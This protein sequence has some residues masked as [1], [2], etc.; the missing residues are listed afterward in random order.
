MDKA[1][2]T[3]MLIFG[4]VVVAV[5]A[6]V[7]LWAH[8]GYRQR[9]AEAGSAWTAIAGRA[10]PAADAFSPDMI[11]G[12]PEVARRYFTHAIA[13]GTPLSTTVELEMEGLFRLGEKDAPREFAMHARQ[14]LAPPSEFVW[15]P[16]LRSGLLRVTGSD[17]LLDG[18]AWTRFWLLGIV[19]L[20]QA[21]ATDALYRSAL[22]RPALEAIWAPASLLP[23]SGA[24]WRQTG[25]DSARIALG[26]GRARVEIDMTVDADGRVLAVSTVRWSDANRERT[27]RLQPFGGTMKVEATF[28][29]FTIPVA[30][31]VG[32]HFGTPDYFPFFSATVIAARYH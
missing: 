25:P 11:A 23:R 29:G 6:A 8:S 9:M 2:W 12:L 21:A 30:V 18:R 22:A 14:I 17:G 24:Q 26:T 5:G 27:F 19:P 15:L 4:V 1:V 31:D 20:V 13:P 3:G 10:R 7:M 32:N 16:V 28:G